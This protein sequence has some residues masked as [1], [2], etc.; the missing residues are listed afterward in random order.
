MF[1]TRD[2]VLILTVVA[3]LL[4][5]IGTTLWGQYRDSRPTEGMIVTTTNDGE[6]IAEVHAPTKLSRADRLAEMRKKISED[7][8]LSIVGDVS[9]IIEGGGEDQLNILKSDDVTLAAS[10]I[11]CPGYTN[12]TGTWSPVGVKSE[13]VEGGRVFY[14][15]E[16]KVV[17]VTSSTEPLTER[18]TLLQLPIQPIVTASTHCIP[19]DVVGVALDGSLIRNNEL[20]LYSVFGSETMIGYALDGF[21]IQGAGATPVD[22]CG[23]ASVGGQYGYYL[24]TERETIINCFVAPPVSL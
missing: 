15:E 5:A 16:T 19:N 11:R 7:E 12:Y 23:G 3:F 8:S 18:V 22:D 24:N 20:M 1:R 14:K 10:E 4:M 2:F 9:E 6:Y 21:P 17:M 13:V